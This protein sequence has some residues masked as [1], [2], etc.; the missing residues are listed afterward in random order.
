MSEIRRPLPIAGPW[1]TQH[2][3]ALVEEAARSAWYERAG[4]F[5]HSF[6]V[7]FAKYVGRKHAVALPSCTSALHLALLA[8]GVGPGDEVIL[9]DA[10]WIASAAPVSYVG[11]TPVFADID[12][13][14][15]CLDVRSV[16]ECLSPRT[17]AI[18][19]VDL[20]GSM[21][22]MDS[23][24]QIAEEAG[25][26]LVEDA[27]EAIGSTRAGRPAGSFGIASAFSFHGSKTLTTGEGG[28]IVLD[29]DHLHERV[30]FLR[31]HGRKEGDTSFRNTEVAYKYKMSDL[32]AAFGLG[33]LR[34]I[35]ELVQRKREIFSSYANRLSACADVA[36]NHEPEDV[37]N[38]YWMVTAVLP[39]EMG[40]G[41]DRLAEALA[42]N[43]IGTRPFFN[44]LSSLE[45]YA[46]TEQAARASTR[47]R[48]SY[49][50]AP[51]GL[52]LPSALVLSD[53]DVDRVCECLLRILK[54]R[55]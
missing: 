39:P 45:A 46:G 27:A 34:R 4:E 3:V 28:M 18:I 54:D 50:I 20:Y 43:D 5:V 9:P 7:E 26:F 17:K 52:N 2:E 47:N 41:K 19:P 22:D 16:A 12:P 36:L 30:R 14:T 35:D 8:L 51:Y 40:L 21:P 37:R 1:V 13:L 33:Q 31:D 48:V 32:Q 6:E 15:W 49:R 10:T 24:S 55:S 11:A 44:P 29:D 53:E 42:D 38:S 25:V 23:L